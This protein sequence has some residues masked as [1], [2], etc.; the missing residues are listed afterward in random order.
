MRKTE[1]AFLEWPKELP[2]SSEVED[3]ALQRNRVELSGWMA[4]DKPRAGRLMTALRRTARAALKKPLGPF[5]RVLDRRFDT[6]S[7]Q[8]RA[9]DRRTDQLL[10]VHLD[11]LRQDVN[12]DLETVAELVLTLERFALEFSERSERITE[13]LESLLERMKSPRDARGSASGLGSG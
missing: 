13:I 1:R 6:L 4:F 8:L 7:D 11:Q 2:T 5:L 3:P 12:T 10:Q 9:V